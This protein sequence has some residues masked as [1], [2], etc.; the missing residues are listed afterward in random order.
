MAVDGRQPSLAG[1]AGGIVVME[2]TIQNQTGDIRLKTGAKK[3]V[4]YPVI[5]ASNGNGKSVVY[6]NE[7]QTP[8]VTRNSTEKLIVDP[9]AS[10][11]EMKIYVNRNLH[12]EDSLTTKEVGIV[13]KVNEVMP[14]RNGINVESNPWTNAIE[15][16]PKNGE[17]PLAFE[18]QINKLED[19]TVIDAELEVRGS[20]ET[21]ENSMETEKEATQWEEGEME[22]GEI[23]RNME[24]DLYKDNVVTKHEK[25]EEN[26]VMLTEENV[27]KHKTNNNRDQSEQVYLQATVT[28]FE[29][30][31]M[32]VDTNLVEVI[33]IIEQVNLQAVVTNFEGILSDADA[34]PVDDVEIVQKT[35]SNNVDSNV[36]SILHTEKEGNARDD[37]AEIDVED[38]NKYVRFH[39]KMKAD[40]AN[41]MVINNNV[42]DK[43]CLMEDGKFHLPP[44]SV[45]HKKKSNEDY[46]RKY[47]RKEIGKFWW[48]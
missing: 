23:M 39:E 40:G 43:E 13:D 17:V 9:S 29:G 19:A 47:E 15:H 42:N 31:L 34:K 26:T 33:E 7:V 24:E 36:V 27:R 16:Q 12:F 14:S 8:R 30:I 45:H 4:D 48:M 11:F 5:R 21:T 1:S 20:I 22:E 18:M 6:E 28:N 35:F 32:D 3:S 38:I 41:S 25:V 10:S 44:K 46:Q 2:D 37:L